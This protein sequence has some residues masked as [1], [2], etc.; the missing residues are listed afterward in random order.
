MEDFKEFNWMADDNPLNFAQFGL[1]RRMPEW[2]K[3]R[4]PGGVVLH[5]GPG[6]KYIP[7]AHVMEYPDYDFE[8]RQIVKTEGF[9][10]WNTGQIK[11]PFPYDDNTVD[12]VFACHVLEHISDP[13]PL[14]DEVARVLK[15]GA[16]FNIVVPNAH[17]NIFFQD[18]D[19]KTAFVLDTW[20]T[21]FDNPYYTKGKSHTFEVGV[22]FNFAVKEGNGVTV[23]QLL[24]RAL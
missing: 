17:Q 3:T 2:V 9:P 1:D 22:N 8:P 24:K 20:K 4:M 10:L 7:G 13:R 14:I 12:G 21:H 5:L 19:H 11:T 16:P 6:I 15:P 23:T 18:L